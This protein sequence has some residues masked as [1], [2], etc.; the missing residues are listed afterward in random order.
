MEDDCWSIEALRDVSSMAASIALKKNL[1]ATMRF[2]LSS[3][4]SK[5]ENHETYDNS[6][7]NCIHGPKYVRA[8]ARR[9]EHWES[10]HP[11]LRKHQ[12]CGKPYC[13]Q[14]QE[15]LWEYACSYRA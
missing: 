15:Y 1:M 9:N 8:C 6:T 4:D 11:P 3:R 12:R 10:R 14:T 2:S 7:G 5:G 13:N